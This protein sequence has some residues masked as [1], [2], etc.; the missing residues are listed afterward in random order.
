MFVHGQPY[1]RRDLHTLWGGQQQGGI[2]TPAKHSLILLF[3]GEQGEQYGYSDGWSEDGIFLYTGEGQRGDMEFVRGNRAIRDHELTGKDLHLF[4]A[5]KKRSFVRY[6]DQVI[7]TGYYRR[8]GPDVDETL[9]QVIVFEL[10]PIGD[11]KHLEF[12]L[13]STETPI[14]RIKGTSLN[15]LRK[16]ALSSS[17]KG[18]SAIARRERIY[19]RSQA[20]R[21]YVLRRSGGKC[22][23]CKAAA[24]FTTPSGNVYLEPH[25]I[26]RLSD[27]GPDHP[28]WVIALCP[29]CHRRAHYSEDSQIFNKKLDEIVSQIEEN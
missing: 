15:E 12:S 16:K 26:R 9:R 21:L 29:N 19:N 2:S 28:R 20:I 13:E 11:F 10:T 23:G 27:G 4:S 17:S 18:T 24:P 14:G 25:H 22:E 8:L 6:V 5:L 7:C 3:T 1:R